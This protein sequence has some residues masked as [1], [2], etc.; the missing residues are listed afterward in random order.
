MDKRKTASIA[1]GITGGLVFSLAGWGVSFA[2]A[3]TSLWAVSLFAALL[4]PLAGL[5]IL[6]VVAQRKEQF[7]RTQVVVSYVAASFAVE[8]VF[9]VIAGTSAS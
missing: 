4:L 2:L 7:F 5:G 6:S 1:L 8:A 9:F 3:K